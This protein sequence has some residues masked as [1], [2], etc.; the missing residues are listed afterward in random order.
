[1]NQTCLFAGCF[2]S[3]IND[4]ASAEGKRARAAQRCD[5]TDEMRGSPDLPDAPLES[6][7]EMEREEEIVG[8][9]CH[10]IKFLPGTW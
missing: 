6:E 2:S 5:P 10:F 4:K 8:T 3:K 7:T 1:M 9:R